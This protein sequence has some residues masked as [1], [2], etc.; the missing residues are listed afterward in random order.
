MYFRRLS[1]FFSFE[2]FLQKVH[3]L[4][5]LTERSNQSYFEMLSKK[6]PLGH[7]IVWGA[8]NKINECALSILFS[9]S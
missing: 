6:V 7:I 4:K 1:L 2:F 5:F 3:V 9:Y 8:Q